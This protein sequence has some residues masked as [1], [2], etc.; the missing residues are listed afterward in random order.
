[1]TTLTFLGGTGTVTGSRFLIEHEGDRVL[2]DC[3][4]YQGL[5]NLRARNWEPLAVDAG[6]I[7][8]VVLTHAHLDHCGYLPRLVRDGFAGPVVC[9]ADTAELAAIILRDSAHLQEEDAAYARRAGFSKHHPPM[10]LYTAQDAEKAI[11]L[12]QPVGF[13]ED[14]PLT[15]E[16]GVTLRPAGHILGSSTAL[17]MAGETKV[18][19]SG[20]LGRPSHPLLKAPAPPADA[21]VVVVESTYG[22]RVHP[23]ADPQLLADVIRRTAR[24]G[25]V[26]LIPAFAVDRTE[27]VLAE[28]ERLRQAGQI[29]DLPVYLDS[30]MALAAVEVYRSAL[31]EQHPDVRTGIEDPLE[32]QDFVA[33]HS[34]LESSGLN[35]P[36][37]ACIIISA[38]GMATGGRVLHHLKHQLP[39]PTNTVVL[40]GFQAIGT[41]G[42]DLLEGAQYL[43]IHGVYVPVRAE[44]VDATGFSC[45]AD[46][47]DM[48]AWLG[49]AETPPHT[50][51]VVHGEAEGSAALAARIHDELGW[52]AVP[53][54][55]NERV[56]VAPRVPTA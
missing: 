13:F 36:T 28:L 27:V 22:G 8:A 16:V 41:R 55:L 38:S 52:C 15:D 23:P 5:T 43:K 54:H 50:V 30:P 35:D 21:D 18:L 11:L 17:I 9:T 49:Q 31:R 56:L 6:T 12:L 1:M 2:V 29:P 14:V 53:P 24:R 45:H 3:G 33:V 10:P 47:D 34:A 20:D 44:I 25:G 48:M 40:A 46:A 51:Y 32:P 19:F 26:V 39:H 4:L 37:H 7:D 42:R